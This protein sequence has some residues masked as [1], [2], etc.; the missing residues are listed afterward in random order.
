MKKIAAVLLMAIA[1]AGCQARA[2]TAAEVQADDRDGREYIAEL[3]DAIQRADRI[4]VTEHSSQF[5]AYDV[6]SGKSLVPE[7]IVYGTRQLGSQQKALFL[8]TVEQ[9]DPKTQ[10]A[11]PACIFESHH[12]VMFYAGGNLESTMDI[13]FQCG[14][15]KWSAT[16]TTPPWSLYSGLAAFIEGIGFQ[17]E[18]DWAALAAQT[19]Q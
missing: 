19:T 10:D 2:G 15:V 17:P 8:S 18:R 4:V 13:C 1:A 12:T 16:R 9:L 3:S 5:D 14:Q 6:T 7:E 11:F